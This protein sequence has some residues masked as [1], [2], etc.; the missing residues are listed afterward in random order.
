M[1][2]RAAAKGGHGAERRET[3][4]LRAVLSQGPKIG[5]LTKTAFPPPRG[6]G[7]S[8]RCP[9]PPPPLS[10]SPSPIFP[11]FEPWGGCRAPAPPLAVVCN[12]QNKTR[13]PPEKNSGRLSGPKTMACCPLK[14]AIPAICPPVVFFPKSWYNVPVGVQGT[15]QL[16]FFV[17]ST[18]LP[19]L[20]P[21]PRPPIDGF[22]QQKMAV[23]LLLEKWEAQKSSSPFW[24]PR[25]GS[26]LPPSRAPTARS[27]TQDN[28]A[29]P[30]S[31]PPPP[32]N[33]QVQEKRF[34]LFRNFGCRRKKPLPRANR[35]LPNFLPMAP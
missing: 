30:D 7:N 14:S 28:R 25:K 18:A 9:P 12:A 26:K 4:D 20:A 24:S 35:G 3:P 32:S 21:P 13:H 16:S 22:L 19:A 29:G 11:F 27:V 10:L 5:P 34:A 2:S 33:T 31:V 15:N 17:G 6:K 1:G 8:P 23:A